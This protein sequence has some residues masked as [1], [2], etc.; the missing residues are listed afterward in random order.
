M[1]DLIE[2]LKGT[3][4][5]KK[6]WKETLK[7]P[8]GKTRSYKDIAIAIGHPKAYRAVANA[9]GRNPRPVVIPCHRVISSNGTLG[10]YSGKGGLHT[11]RKLLKSEGFI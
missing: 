2:D 4:F 1:Y 10:G 8:K 7:I 5:D 9:L 6:V 3:A 11:K